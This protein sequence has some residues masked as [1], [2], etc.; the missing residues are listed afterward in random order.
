VREG[1]HQQSVDAHRTK[2]LLLLRQRQDLLR[3]A[4]WGDDAKRVRMKRDD[5]RRPL[6]L[7]RALNHAADDLLM[8]DVH[9][10]EVSDR[11]DATA[12]EVRLAQGIVKDQHALPRAV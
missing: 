6:S 4:V 1:N 5:R 10:V 8:A 3:H 11:G 9:A 2:D 7:T 12:R